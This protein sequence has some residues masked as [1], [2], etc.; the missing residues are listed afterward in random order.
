M[1]HYSPHSH[2]LSTLI[3]DWALLVCYIV[4]VV[5]VGV[6]VTGISQKG[7][8]VVVVHPELQHLL[9]LLFRPS[10][11]GNQCNFSTHVAPDVN[12]SSFEDNNLSHDAVHNPA[13]VNIDLH[14]EPCCIEVLHSNSMDNA[15]AGYS[16]AEMD[17]AVGKT[18]RIL[19]LLQ[20]LSFL[21]L[22]GPVLEQFGVSDPVILCEEN[23]S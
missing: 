14:L 11:I 10:L 20:C 17:D 22:P 3:H 6:G 4:A 21:L 13:V 15:K 18:D 1:H 19:I 23:R 9:L 8:A 7:T 2:D 16:D 5:D 12:E